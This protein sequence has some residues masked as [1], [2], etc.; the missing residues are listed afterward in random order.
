MVGLVKGSMKKTIG[1]KRLMQE[2]LQTLTTD[3]EAVVDCRPITP[4]TS[5]NTTV[6]RPVDFLL[7][8]GNS[9]P[10][11]FRSLENDARDPTYRD[12]SDIHQKL[13]K[14][15]EET[16][17]ELDNFWTIWREEYLMMLSERYQTTHKQ[18]FSIEKRSPEV[19]E[20]VLL[21]ESPYPRGTW[22][23]GVIEALHPEPSKVR[24]ATIR[25]S[26]ATAA[27]VIT[28]VI[29]ETFYKT[30]TKRKHSLPF[31][32]LPCLLTW[33]LLTSVVGSTAASG[34]Q[35]IYLP[36][37]ETENCRVERFSHLTTT[38]I[39]VFERKLKRVEAISCFQITHKICT[40]AFLRF[41]MYETLEEPIISAVTA[42]ACEEIRNTKRF[43]GLQLESI[44][45][46]RWKSSQP[47]TAS[48]A[49]FGER[50]TATVNYELLLT[51]DDVHIDSC[52]VNVTACKASTGKCMADG[53]IILWDKK[54]LAEQCTWYRVTEKM[55]IV[56][57]L[58]ASFVPLEAFDESWRKRSSVKFGPMQ[59]V[60][61]S[62]LM[63]GNSKM[64]LTGTERQE[65]A[66]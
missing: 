30:V 18:P 38:R 21:N 14:Y 59:M 9:S 41:S 44:G 58:Q 31:Y 28:T 1:R 20:T 29:R 48:Y 15:W 47:S 53:R 66:H 17:A 25:L 40:R 52:L 36:I 37:P 24:T 60:F 8:H 51:G 57:K 27:T 55:I 11:V 19:N 56:E 61:S 3:A 46:K 32:L 12:P 54:M 13:S 62:H 6:L 64:S 16:T 34:T 45:A 33:G 49:I 26:N 42:Q 5:E 43:S 2:E 50:C 23:L 39:S 63:T 65:F 35:G 4:F 10:G 22:P 7:P